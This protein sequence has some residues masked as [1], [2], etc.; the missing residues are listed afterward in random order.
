VNY[1]LAD[2]GGIG[3]L[4]AVLLPHSQ[5]RG[6]GTGTAMSRTKVMELWAP[7]VVMTEVLSP[8]TAEV[9]LPAMADR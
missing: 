9:G 4:A 7:L 5:D 6:V 8:T 2:C 3:A 1:Y